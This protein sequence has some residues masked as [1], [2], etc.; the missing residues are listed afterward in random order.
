MYRILKDTE[1]N[2]R[3]KAEPGLTERLEETGWGEHDTLHLLEVNGT[4]VGCADVTE[5]GSYMEV[6]W[7]S[8]LPEHKKKGYGKL[9]L[10]EWR[11][12]YTRFY[13]HGS[14]LPESVGFWFKM[15][16]RFPNNG[17]ERYLEDE[18]E[19]DLVEFELSF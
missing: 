13:L 6:H 9:F 11:K 2:A 15:G 8:I 12:P 7:I 18:S 4:I 19:D 17:L 1:A 5:D 16:A 10:S 3:L 14:S